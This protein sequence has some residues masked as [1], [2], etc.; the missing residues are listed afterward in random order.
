[1]GQIAT[2]KVG[3]FPNR[4]YTFRGCVTDPFEQFGHGHGPIGAVGQVNPIDG[5]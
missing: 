2:E 4:V 3:F 5:E 1:M